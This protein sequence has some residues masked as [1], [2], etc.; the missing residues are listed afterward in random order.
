VQ[1]A[2]FIVDTRPP[3]ARALEVGCGDG[4]LTIALADR[5]YD[6]TGIDP[7]APSGDLFRRI[8]LEDLEES[9]PYDVVVAVRSL[10]HIIDL[11]SA[12]DKIVRLL[13]GRGMLV[14]DEFAWD[15]LDAAT[16][17]WF[18]GQQRSGERAASVDD[19]RRDWDDEHVGL[20][21][22]DALRTAI[23]ARF[24][25]LQFEWRPYLHRLLDSVPAVALERSLIES[26]AIR[27]LGFRYTGTPRG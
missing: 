14:V 23:D 5:G 16:A 4:A 20:H 21:G 19:C 15:R 11:D 7:A 6:V 17:E 1:L 26:R 2:D 27:P 8:K 10:H 12:L 9:E 18:Y 13:R 24:D 22:Y 3:P 25:E